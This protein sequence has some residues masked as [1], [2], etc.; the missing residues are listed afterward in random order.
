MWNSKGAFAKSFGLDP[1]RV[2]VIVEYLGGGF[3]SKAWSHRIS[4][5]AAKLSMMTGRPVKMEQTR[6]EEFLTH[7][8][9]YDCKI[10]LKMGARKDGKLTAI[11]ERALL[12]IGTAAAN[13]NYNPN[14]IIWQTSNLYDCSNVHLEQIGVFTNLQQTG[15]TRAPFNM[16]SLFALESHIDRM[17]EATGMDP[18]AFR[19]KNYK[20]HA[21]THAKSALMGQEVKVAWSNKRLDECMRQATAAIGWER[22]KVIGNSALGPRKRGIGM[23]SFIAHQGGGIPPNTAHADV[24]INHEGVV[25]LHVGVVDIGGGQ[26]T[27]F[28]MIAAEEL[29]VEA[30]NVRVVYGDTRDTRYAPSCHSSRCTAETGPPVLQAAA[31]ARQKLFRIAAPLLGAASGDLDSRHGEIYLKSNPARSIPFKTVC[32]KIDPDDPI[33]GS[34]S[35]EINPDDPIFSSFGAQAAE[36]EVDTETGEVTI[37]RMT[38]AQDFGRAINPKLCI[39][40]ITGGIEFGVGYALSEEGIYDRKTGKM[41][42]TNFHQYRLPTSLDM[43]SIDAYLVESRDP[44]FAFDARGGAEVTNTPTPAAIANALHNALGVWFNELPITPDKIIEALRAQKKE[45]R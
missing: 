11:C 44:Y 14:R 5:Y 15:P 2:R 3:G 26:R 24:K 34:G 10:H 36:V 30:A 21:S 39:S 45:E 41:L 4:Y 31:E 42:N 28:A 23:A 25:S 6:A 37:L 33:H 1:E 35:R 22:R 43:P 18:L 12:N 38:A 27:I 8:H 32:A 7:P 9:R 19:M 13:N 20:T 29:G 16:P 17:A 40:Q